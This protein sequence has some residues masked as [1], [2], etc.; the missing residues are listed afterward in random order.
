MQNSDWV[1]L[2]TLV[3][4]ITSSII[5]IIAAIQAMRTHE[6]VKVVDAKVNGAIDKVIAVAKAAGHDEAVAA[7]AIADSGVRLGQRGN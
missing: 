6:A 7:Q 5:S 4:V 1:G 2:I 3:G